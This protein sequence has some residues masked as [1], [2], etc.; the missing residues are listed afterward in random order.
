M[1]QKVRQKLAPPSAD[2][3]GLGKH[4]N[5]SVVC[6]LSQTVLQNMVCKKAK[7]GGAKGQ[8]RT[9]FSDFFPK[10]QRTRK[11]FRCINILQPR[12]LQD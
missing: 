9:M 1:T 2:W 12:N 6:L 3:K 4:K 10:F 7:H 11:S 8:Y 5:V